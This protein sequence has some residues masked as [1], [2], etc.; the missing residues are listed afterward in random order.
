MALQLA[1]TRAVVGRCYRRPCLEFVAKHVRLKKL[2]KEAVKE[3]DD[4]RVRIAA[5]VKGDTR[6]VEI[7]R[8]EA[9]RDLQMERDWHK[10]YKREHTQWGII[11][12]Y[13]HD[14]CVVC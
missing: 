9:L 2:Y 6:N 8:D 5:T 12:T 11:P 14:V 4:E 3:R 10:R 1:G 7:E 13:V